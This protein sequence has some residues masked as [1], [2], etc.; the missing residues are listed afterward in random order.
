MDVTEGWMKLHNEE[1]CDLFFSSDNIWIIKPRRTR[2]AANI[3]HIVEKRYSIYIVLVK[4]PEGK[5]RLGRPR[6]RWEDSL[7][8]DLKVVI[9]EGIN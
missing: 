1:L 6:R 9:L 7:K 2:W 8:M 3:A 4:K 5:K